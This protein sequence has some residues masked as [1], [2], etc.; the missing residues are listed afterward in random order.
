MRAILPSLLLLAGSLTP[1][2]QVGHLG[3]GVIWSVANSSQAAAFDLLSNHYGSQ[4]KRGLLDQILGSLGQGNS[5]NADNSDSNGNRNGNG[6][7]RDGAETVT[8]TKILRQTITVGGGGVVGG[9]NATA[10][11]STVTVTK[12]VAAAGG[13]N[14]AYVLESIR[15]TLSANTEIDNY[16]FSRPPSSRRATRP[17]QRSPPS[18]PL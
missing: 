17:P 3:R 7:N 11:V 4:V 12:E 8:E 1:V 9:L 16:S 6:R 5:N 10:A 15:S 13:E 2:A 14:A 18:P